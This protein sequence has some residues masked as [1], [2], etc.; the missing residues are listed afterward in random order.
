V[1]GGIVL[2]KKKKTSVL[3]TI[4]NNVETVLG[5]I[6]LILSC[7]ILTWQVFTRYVLGSASTWSE[8]AARFMF[9]WIIFLGCSYAMKGDE[10][11]RVDSAIMV[12]PKKIRKYAELIGDLLCFVLAGIILYYGIRYTA[13]ARSTGQFGAATF[14]PLWYVWLAVPACY[15]MMI[16][17][18]AVNFVKKYIDHIDP[19]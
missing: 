8:E 2:N 3:L 12:W 10:H 15:T 14:F 7:I 1:K 19:H 5:A 4:Y 13:N 6:L 9:V 18:M 16:S 11:I 17:R